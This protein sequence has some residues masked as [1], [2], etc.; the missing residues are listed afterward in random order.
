MDKI[1]CALNITKQF[2][3][4]RSINCPAVE[5]IIDEALA[6]HEQAKA[7]E[8]WAETHGLL[9]AWGAWQKEQAPNPLAWYKQNDV[10]FA[11]S[12]IGR[13]KISHCRGGY[14]AELDSKV[15]IW[16]V[17]NLKTVE[18]GMQLAHN[19]LQRFAL[20]CIFGG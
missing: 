2:L 12:P 16:G 18:E 4:S 7:F 14:M 15:V 11:V 20:R 3:N 5:Y 9:L 17:V 6:E 8:R 1:R 13:F 19:E 10:W